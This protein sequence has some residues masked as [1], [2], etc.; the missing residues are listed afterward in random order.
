MSTC[1]TFSML[2]TGPSTI[3]QILHPRNVKELQAFLGKINFLRRFIHNLAELIRLMNNMIRK[4]SK[5][6]GIEEAKKAFEEIKI[7]LTKT[8]ALTSPKFERDF[9]I[10]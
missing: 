7:A 6:N 1:I 4:D 8:P 9:I 5:V 3:L 10:F 2:T